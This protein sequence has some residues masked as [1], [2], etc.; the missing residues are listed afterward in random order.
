[1]FPEFLLSWLYWVE[2]VNI[3]ALPSDGHTHIYVYPCVF[4][5]MICVLTLYLI[6]INMCSKLY[7]NQNVCLCCDFLE[8]M[9]K[10]Q[11]HN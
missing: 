1:M 5:S 2:M 9:Q 3:F 11:P 7:L 10:Y 4:Y 6:Y 8:T